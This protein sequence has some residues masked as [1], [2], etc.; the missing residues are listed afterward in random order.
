MRASPAF[1]AAIL[2][3][4]ATLTTAHAADGWGLPEE[5]ERSL[6]GTVVDLVCELTGD[7]PAE[8]GAGTRQLGI[9]TD[10]GRL[11]FPIKGNTFFAGA[12]R[13]LLPY[14]GRPVMVD[15][16]FTSNH[17]NTVYFLQY[18]RETE[19]EDWRSAERFQADWAAARGV[20]PD[21]PEAQEWFRNDP[22]VQDVIGRHGK[23]GISE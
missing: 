12:V 3:G 22:T 21:G 7:C 6:T 20:A 1:A 11:V 13:D 4:L 10:D 18:I 16:L 8:C 2:F 5:R 23:L 19:S 14:C 15:G 9:K 17:G